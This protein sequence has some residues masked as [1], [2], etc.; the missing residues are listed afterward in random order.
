MGKR[1]A[2][3]QINKDDNDDVC[4]M[5]IDED[6]S[7]SVTVLSTKPAPKRRKTA[8]PKSLKVVVWDNTFGLHIGQTH[9]P[10]CNH[11]I[12]SQMDFHC[13]HIIPECEGGETKAYNLRPICA[14]CNLSMGRKNLKDFHKKYFK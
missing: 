8:I 12:I 13:G 10:V 14:K 11:H 2:P 4:P 3:V 6:A 9:C 1:K 7:V 5:D